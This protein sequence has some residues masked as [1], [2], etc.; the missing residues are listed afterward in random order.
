MWGDKR[1]QL[2][3]TVNHYIFEFKCC[4]SGYNGTVIVEKQQMFIDDGI[5]HD[6]GGK[7]IQCGL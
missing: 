5:I 3:N 7:E 6:K 2:E 4:G 1:K